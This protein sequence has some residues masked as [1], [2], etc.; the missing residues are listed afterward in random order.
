MDA[1]TDVLRII[2]LTGGVFLEASFTAPWCV[3]SRIGPEDCRPYLTNTASVICFHYVLSGHMHVAVDG[4]GPVD[5]GGNTIVLLPRNDAHLLASGPGIPPVDSHLL[6]RTEPNG[7]LS[8][9]EHG[10]GGEAT[11]I[12]CGFVGSESREHPLF[13]ALPRVMAM[14]LDGRPGSDWIARSF[15]HAAQEVASGRPAAGTMLAKLSELLF[16]EALREYTAGLPLERT[17]WLAA[18]RE[19]A[20]GRALARMHAQIAHPWTTEALAAEAHLSR[21]AFADRFT[22]LLDV[23]PMSYLTRW[24]MQVAAQRLR[25]TLHPISQIAA[26]VGYESEATFTRAFKREMGSAPGQY[27]RSRV[28]TS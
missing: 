25:E 15:Q 3:S 8:S 19:P 9:I 20:I 14:N 4:E 12:V 11:R 27:R 24:R 5:V 23:P 7:A 26:D 6:I 28:S 2:R 1:L 16:V 17:G 13:N 21:S 18:L 10:G 22:Q